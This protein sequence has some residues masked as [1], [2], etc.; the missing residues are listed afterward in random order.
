MNRRKFLKGGIAAATMTP[1]MASFA[2]LLSSLNSSV[3]KADTPSEYK[4]LVCMFL[5]GGMDNHDT[6]IPYDAPNYERWAKVRRP[7]LNSKTKRAR[8]DLNRLSGTEGQQQYALPPELSGIHSLYEQGHAAVIANVGPLIRPTNAS[9]YDSVPNIQ[10][11]RLFSHNDQQSTWMSGLPEGARYGWGGRL[12]DALARS[13]HSPDTPFNN[14]STGSGELLLTGARSYPYRVEG[15]QA[16]QPYILEEADGELRARLLRHFRSSHYVSSKPIQQDLARKMMQSFDANQ[17]YNRATGG[18][19]IATKF[20]QTELGSQLW[21]VANT[22]AARHQLGVARQ[23]FSVDLGGFDTHSNQATTLP[24][25]QQQMSA[26]ITSFYSALRELGL[27]NQVTLF[28]A[29]D[30]GRTLAVN[31]DGTDHGWGGHH[32][33]IGGAVQG[34][35]IIG[36]MPPP[37]FG[38]NQDAG[39]GR[40]IPTTSVDQYAAALG[41]WLGASDSA[42]SEI[43]PNLKNFTKIN[44]LFKS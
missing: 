19:R 44:G 8:E 15:G 25:L 35:Q 21:S 14:I 6:V 22:M 37:T 16:R 39:N 18:V 20:P 7:L 32:F 11:A 5:Y 12:S 33:V 13:G 40:L 27:E 42:L 2:G 38:H 1:C 41:S 29:S 26:A 10:P 17:S 34:R 4:A 9:N 3:A 24:Q 36:A 31:D 28:T 23:I 30:F 43:F